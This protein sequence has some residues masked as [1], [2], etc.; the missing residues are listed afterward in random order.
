MLTATDQHGRDFTIE[1]NIKLLDF[2]TDAKTVYLTGVCDEGAG[3][4]PR[5]YAGGGAI[6]GNTN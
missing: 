2:V 5:L 4:A 1:F 3:G 6:K